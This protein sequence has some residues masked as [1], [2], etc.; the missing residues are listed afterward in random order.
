KISD[1]VQEKTGAMIDIKSQSHYQRQATA[2]QM[3]NINFM[4][5]K[6]SLGSN[7]AALTITNLKLNGMDI[8]GSYTANTT[9]DIFWHLIYGEF[10][11]NFT[12]TG[13]INIVNNSEL[14]ENDNNV[15]V[16]FGSSSNLTPAAL[17]VYWGEIN[18]GQKN[19]ANIINW[20]TN[21]EENNDRF[22]IERATDG[23]NFTGIG[24]VTGAGNRTTL[25]TYNFTDKEFSEGDN[26]Y[27]IKQVDMDGHAS[28]SVVV[29]IS[30]N[31]TGIGFV[32]NNNSLGGGQP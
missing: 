18:A 4:Q 6:L 25:S 32:S 21:K 26:F 8:T 30:N 2:Y 3:Q 5:L 29:H 13:T 9:G 27:R 17:S 31:T 24:F 11:S 20:N 23:L 10:G 16:S 12:V 1:S 14:L 19:R 28:Y 7:N 15:E 22:I